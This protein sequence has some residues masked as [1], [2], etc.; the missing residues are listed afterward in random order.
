VRRPGD[1]LRLAAPAAGQRAA[2][3][4][5]AA[6]PH[7]VRTADALPMLRI[8]GAQEEQEPESESL[9]TEGSETTCSTRR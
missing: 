1:K 4:G 7:V 2:V 9:A 5:K 6:P 8:D 3:T